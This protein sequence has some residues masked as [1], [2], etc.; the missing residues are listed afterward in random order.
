MRKPFKYLG[1]KSKSV[2]HLLSFIPYHNTYVEVFGGSATLLF[3]KDPSWKEIYNDLNSSLYNFFVV[4]RDRHQEFF[5]YLQNTPISR[6]LYGMDYQN[7]DRPEIERAVIFFIRAQ[8]SYGAKMNHVD[9]TGAYSQN[10]RP[11]AR[12]VLAYRARLRDVYLENIEYQRI[13]E[14]YD[15]P[16]TF[17]YLDPPYY[18]KQS[19]IGEHW[20]DKDHFLLWDCLHSIKGR[21][22]VSYRDE[23][24]V[25]E[26]YKDCKIREIRIARDLLSRYDQT[27]HETELVITNYE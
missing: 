2:S 5:K 8:T 15:D 27:H 24:Q 9:F 13:L 6:E 14:K 4:L 12:E 16:S 22:L 18:S 3:A 17:F 26:L 10:V 21:W 20:T 11:T 7:N 1:G 19:Y 23:P 25:R